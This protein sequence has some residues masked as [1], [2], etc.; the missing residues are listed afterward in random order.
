MDGSRKC[1][2]FCRRVL[3]RLRVFFPQNVLHV[4]VIQRV[5]R[6]ALAKGVADSYIYI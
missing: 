4:F 5:T 6:A 1:L 2:P 3:E